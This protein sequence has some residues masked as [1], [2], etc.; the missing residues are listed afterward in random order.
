MAEVGEGTFVA[1]WPP[2]VL[3][4]LPASTPALLHTPLGLPWGRAGGLALIVPLGKAPQF[5][6]K[7]LGLKEPMGTGC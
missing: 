7:G 2:P 5:P 6:L 1:L 3:A 4:I